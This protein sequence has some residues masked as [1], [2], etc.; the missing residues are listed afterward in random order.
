MAAALVAMASS[1]H[2][3][4]HRQAAGAIARKSLG[5]VGKAGKL[6]KWPRWDPPG[7]ATAPDRYISLRGARSGV[8]E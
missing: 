5:N 4:E 1:T 2:C 6:V 3:G 7:A 8:T